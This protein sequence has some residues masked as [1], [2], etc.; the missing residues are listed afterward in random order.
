MRRNASK[1]QSDLAERSAHILAISD[2]GDIGRTAIH[3][4]ILQPLAS[5]TINRLPRTLS[6]TGRHRIRLDCVEPAC[7]KRYCRGTLNGT[8]LGS[9]IVENEKMPQ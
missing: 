1:R 8:I 6:N 3:P 2:F 4:A 7:G 5:A 9:W